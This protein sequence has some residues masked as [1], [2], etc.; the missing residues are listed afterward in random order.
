M[1][2]PTTSNQKHRTGLLIYYNSTGLLTGIP[3]RND[4]MAEFDNGMTVILQQSLSD[5]Q[6]IH[7]MLTEVSDNTS[8]YVNGISSYILHITGTLINGQKAVIKITG[9]KLFFDVEVPEEMPLSTFKTRLVNI[10]S[11]TLKGT[12]KFGIENISASYGLI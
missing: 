8:E 5:K 10:L 6:P 11:N 7:F 9:I 4:I 2:T 12:S 3:S 1:H